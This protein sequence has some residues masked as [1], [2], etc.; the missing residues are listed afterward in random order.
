MLVTEDLK[1]AAAEA[2]K[3]RKESEYE[4]LIC[5][6]EVSGSG[7]NI[8]TFN[9]SIEKCSFLLSE[10]D[11]KF[12][13]EFYN[14]HSKKSLCC[15]PKG[16]KGRCYA[17]YN[18]VFAEQF[19]KKI[20][21]CS[22]APGNSDI[23]F[24]NRCKRTYPVQVSKKQYTVINSHHKLKANKADLKAAIPV[25]NGG[26]SFTIATAIYDFTSL[27]MLQKGIQHT[28]SD[29]VVYKLLDRA[30]DVVS[31]LQDEGVNI[32]DENGHL[33]DPVLGCTLEPEWYTID[34][35]RSPYQIQF[36]HVNPLRADKYMTRGK[37]VIP[38]TR[39]ANLIQSDTPLSQ[40]HE[41][42]K[43]AYEHTATRRLS[44]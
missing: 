23:L 4:N 24:K 8:K 31:H 20:H 38:L 11:I 32:L 14:K 26:T 10:S 29:D 22:Q 9:S 1:S 18:G 28:L 6:K 13:T 19:A 44:S 17:G 30:Q 33:C 12:Y 34:D 7:V 36:G 41:F 21:D 43:D 37:N 16:H 3:F 42:I 27:M 25:E 2:E 5:L 15:L 39:R 35:D 40:V